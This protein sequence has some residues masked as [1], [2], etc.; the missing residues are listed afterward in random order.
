MTARSNLLPVA[1]HYLFKAAVRVL[2]ISA[3]WTSRAKSPALWRTSMSDGKFR[4]LNPDGQ[5]CP[6]ELLLFN[7]DIGSSKLKPAH[8]RFLNQGILTILE[9]NGEHKVGLVG[10]ASRSG[11]DSFDLKLSRQRA[12]AV[13]ALL[14]RA[15]I[16]RG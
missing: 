10:R 13:A 9:A 3:H 1:P 11:P 8:E 4:P 6:T 2:A 14:T 15:G 5:D 12:E 16:D 7:F